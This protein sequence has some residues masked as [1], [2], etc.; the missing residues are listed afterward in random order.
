MGVSETAC[1]LAGKCIGALAQTLATFF[2]HTHT[3]FSFTQDTKTCQL[4]LHYSWTIIC[5]FSSCSL[6]SRS[7]IMSYSAQNAVHSGWMV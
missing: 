1:V 6:A 5:I 2:T 7:L 3:Q 4:Q